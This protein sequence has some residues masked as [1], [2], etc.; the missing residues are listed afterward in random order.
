MLRILER[1]KTFLRL[2]IELEDGVEIHDLDAGG[3]VEFLTRNG[4]EHLFRNA[5]GVRVTVGAGVTQQGA[6][7]G[8]EAEIHAPGVYADGLRDNPLPAQIG[9]AVAEMLVYSQ[10][11]PI[12]FAAQ[13]DDA[14]GE[15]VHFLHVEGSARKSGQDRTAGS[16]AAVESQ[17]TMLSAHG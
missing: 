10:H 4:L 7:F 11:V 6:V 12:I 8:H 9:Q 13:L 14:A 16:G 2:G 17:E 3:P 5:F 1:R 15:A